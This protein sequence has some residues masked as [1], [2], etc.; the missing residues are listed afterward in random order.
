MATRTLAVML[1]IAMLLAPAGSFHP[2]FVRLAAQPCPSVPAPRGPSADVL[3]PRRAGCSSMLTAEEMRDDGFARAVAAGGGGG[4][5]DG[6]G[7]FILFYMPWCGYCKEI[8]P[9]WDRLADEL[10]GE[11]RSGRSVGERGGLHAAGAAIPANARRVSVLRRCLL[12]V[13]RSGS[14]GK[15]NMESEKATAHR[16]RHKVLACSHAAT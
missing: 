12:T 3:A 5:R 15:L 1:L 11:V 6:E 13:P 16:F 7:W 8:L 9:V 14:I 2:R 4:G 10:K